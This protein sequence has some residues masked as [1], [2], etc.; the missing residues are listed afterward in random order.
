MEPTTSGFVL[1]VIRRD[2]RQ[3]VIAVPVGTPSDAAAR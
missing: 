1:L 3:R 2:G